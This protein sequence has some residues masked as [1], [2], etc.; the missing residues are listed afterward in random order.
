MKNIEELAIDSDAVSEIVPEKIADQIE[1]AAREKRV[2]RQ[3]LRINKDLVDT[4]GSTI[5]IPARGTIDAVDATENDSADTTD[6]SYT[7][8]QVTVKKIE[9]GTKIT[10][11]AIE[12]AK[13]DVIQGNLDE[14]SVALTD[15]EDLDIM[16]T[17]MDR[18]SYT[19]TGD[20]DGSSQE[21]TLPS[22]EAVLKVDSASVDGGS[23]TT[24][25]YTVDYGEA[26][27]K[28]DEAPDSGTD[29]VEVEYDAVSDGSNVNVVDAA[30]TGTAGDLELG[31]LVDART[32]IATNKY[33][34]QYLAVEENGRGD[35]IQQDDFIDANKYG[36][37]VDLANGEIGKIAGVQTLVST[38]LPDNVG[39][40][41]DPDKAG[42]FVLKNNPYVKREESAATDSIEIYA[43]ERYKPAILNPEAITVL[44]G[45]QDD[46][47]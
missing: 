20:G 40:M 25:A 43:R 9:A 18:E 35:I 2:G 33:T 6:T 27:I 17:L 31:D 39:L 28:F 37:Q 44:T 45:F 41:V 10:Q 7:E 38:Q 30:D 32:K 21:F 19:F 26:K 13:F 24:D 12:D 47:Y 5:S 22:G 15:K 14:L 3:L 42:V 23:S 34:P 36:S 16:N 29:N 11:E 8:T 46:A 4:D 1:T